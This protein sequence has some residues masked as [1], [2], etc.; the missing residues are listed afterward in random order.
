[1]LIDALPIWDIRPGFFQDGKTVAIDKALESALEIVLSDLSPTL[2][3]TVEDSE[4]SNFPG[5]VTALLLDAEGKSGGSGVYVMTDQPRIEQIVSLA[6]QVQE[7]AVEAL[8]SRGLGAVWP[9]C[10]LHPDSHPL[11]AR[12]S[13]KGRAV[14]VCPTQNQVIAEVGSLHSNERGGN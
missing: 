5:Q 12:V 6:D 3:P 13:D 11:H 8:W 4:W 7:W 1:M 2:N 14:W 9:E 10:R